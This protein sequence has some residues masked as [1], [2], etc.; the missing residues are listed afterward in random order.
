MDNIKKLEN[1]TPI[2]LNSIVK[3]GSPRNIRV[4]ADGVFDLF[5][6]GHAKQFQQIKELLPDCYLVVG[7]VSDADTLHYKGGNTVNSEAERAEMVSHCRYVDEVYIDPPFY[8][9]LEFV[10]E[11]KCDL[12]AHDDIPYAI[13]D[14]I[15]DCYLPFKKSDRFLA[16]ARTP[17]ISTTS[18]VQK[19][20]DSTEMYQK[21]QE[22]RLLKEHRQFENQG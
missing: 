6:V 16:T 20:L 18:I 13:N 19:I 12:V 21:R 22:I 2:T 9:T 1:W 7:V 8:P 17:C 5:H 10:D 3:Q 4:Y 15:D 14:N 11:I